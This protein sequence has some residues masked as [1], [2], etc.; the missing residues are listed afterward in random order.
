M[1]DQFWVPVKL[2]IEIASTAVIF[3]L[4]FGVLAAFWM[5]KSSFRGKTVIETVLLLPLVL[6]PTVVGFLLI[7]IFGSQS[8]V[9]KWIEDLFQQSIMFTWWAALIAAIIVAFPLM[10]QSVKTGFRSVDPD[11]EAAA[12]IDGANNWQ[13]FLFITIPLSI[14]SI[15]SGT[16]LAFARALG[17]F[18]ATFMFAG[19]IPGKTQT[20]PIAV[21]IALDSG[22]TSLAWMFVITMVLISF[23]ML[24]ITTIIK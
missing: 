14:K 15:I 5:T 7:M 3:A 20:I 6:P 16:I 10:Y 1:N 4:L 2:S 13:V 18:G 23:V 8:P 17:E 24:L 21:Y 11:I 19:N 22:N 12:R 9:G